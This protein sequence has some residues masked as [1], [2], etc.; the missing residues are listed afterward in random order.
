M[1]ILCSMFGK[2]VEIFW[3]THRLIDHQATER[4]LIMFSCGF[5]LRDLTETS[6][7]TPRN[8]TESVTGFELS[9]KH[10]DQNLQEITQTC[11][12]HKPT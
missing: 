12:S 7:D 11:S 4:C 9:A 10:N 5:G 3:D 6:G 8:M 2:C 1:F